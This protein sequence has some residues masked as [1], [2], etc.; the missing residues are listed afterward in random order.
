MNV[1]T[2]DT[3]ITHYT[4]QMVEFYSGMYQQALQTGDHQGLSDAAG[5]LSVAFAMQG[6][7]ALS[8]KWA[9]A[10]FLLLTDKLDGTPPLRS[11]IAQPEAPPL[12][13]FP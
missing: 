7:T 5:I 8:R 3:Y 1:S 10:F 4:G 11:G 2:K 6:K 13:S 12:S 9:E